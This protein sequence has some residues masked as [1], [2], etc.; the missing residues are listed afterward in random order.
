METDRER[1]NSRYASEPYYLGRE[2]S[3]FLMREI[4]R[5]KLLAPGRNALDVACGE[6]RNA[7][8]L[9]KHGFEVTGIDISDEGLKKAGAIASK[10]GFQIRVERLDLDRKRIKGKFALILNINFLMRRIIPDE[11]DAL[12]PG[13]IL[14]FETLLEQKSDASRGNPDY[15]LQ[16][17]ELERIFNDFEGEILSFEEQPEL[18]APVARLVF[19]KSSVAGI[20]CS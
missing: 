6:G 9:A 10:S 17:G 2:P 8:F 4:E 19:R 13:G 11:V 5:A 14:L 20:P 1:W 3:G 18:E 12:L 16:E 15:Y 7:I